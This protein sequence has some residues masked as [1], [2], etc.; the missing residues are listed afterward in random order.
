MSQVLTK[1]LLTDETG[2]DIL[3]KL[4]EIISALSP[5]AQGVSFDKTG[6]Q[7]ITTNNVQDAVK[8]LDTGLDNTNASLTNL[9]KTGNFSGTTD[10]GGNIALPNNIVNTSNS[11]ILAVVSTSGYC[12][13]VAVSGT[14]WYVKVLS[15]NNP[16]TPVANANTNIYYTYILV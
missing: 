16:V 12:T 3:D 2:Q 4:D 1:P 10:S 9:I 6:C 11:V 5:N 13:G 14:T 15:N 7:I 8:Q